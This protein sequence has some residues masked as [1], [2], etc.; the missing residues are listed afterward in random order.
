[1]TTSAERRA[2]RRWQ[3]GATEN[4]IEAAGKRLAD[5][6]AR[7]M[8][9]HRTTDEVATK[10]ESGAS[11]PAELEAVTRWAVAAG[12]AYARAGEDL[13][14]LDDRLK[15]IAGLVQTQGEPA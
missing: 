7:I 6:G 8:D 5:L 10:F 13:R 1:M 9:L 15:Q 2:R 14:R 3:M 12:S 4:P 11:T